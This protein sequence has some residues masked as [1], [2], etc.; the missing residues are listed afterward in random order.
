M[1]RA[2][3]QI[4]LSSQLLRGQTEWLHGQL[5]CFAGQ[6]E[7]RRDVPSYLDVQNL[8]QFETW[9]ETLGESDLREADP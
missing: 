9:L 4:G 2:A 5:R 8:K 7:L 3:P 1:W 6:G